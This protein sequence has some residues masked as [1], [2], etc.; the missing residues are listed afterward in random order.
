MRADG[1]LAMLDRW[2]R[3]ALPGLGLA[4]A[5]VLAIDGPVRA[6]RAT[7]EAGGGE[8]AE[9]LAARGDELVCLCELSEENLKPMARRA[10]QA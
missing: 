5:D 7:T 9:L 8:L 4:H 1:L 2:G 3:A 10:F 6:R